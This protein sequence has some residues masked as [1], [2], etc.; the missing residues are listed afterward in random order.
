MKLSVP[1]CCGN[2]FYMRDYNNSSVCTSP[3]FPEE[4]QILDISSFRVD[5]AKVPE[6]C[7]YIITNKLIDQLPKE[8]QEA[9]DNL[10]NGFRVLF[11]WDV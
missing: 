4:M 6:W 11:G 8:R 1:K 5:P 7:P 3:T 10:Y 2:C 9:L